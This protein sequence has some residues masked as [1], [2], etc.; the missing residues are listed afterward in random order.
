[1]S[2]DWLK[3]F[4]REE[5][6]ELFS[7]IL[8]PDTQD[9]EHYELSREFREKLKA[10]EKRVRQPDYRISIS[11]YTTLIRMMSS[12]I[13]V[14]GDNRL[15]M[16][17]VAMLLESF[18]H[19]K[20]LEAIADNYAACP[21]DQRATLLQLLACQEPAL[22]APVLK[23]LL[24]E[25]GFPDA[26][27]RVFWK[28]SARTDELHQYI[29][30]FVRKPGKYI[31]DAV[32]L[33]NGALEN[34]HL[35]PSQLSELKTLVEEKVI[36][37]IESAAAMQDSARGKWRRDQEY[38]YLRIDLG[39]W[40]D[41]FGII[42]ETSL[43]TLE[44]ALE[45]EDPLIN[46]FLVVA[47]AAKG[48]VPPAASVMSAAQSY[49]TLS[50]LYKVLSAKGFLQAF[51]MEYAT[52]EHFAAAEMVNWLL[53]PDELGEEPGEIELM[54][55]VDAE[56]EC[57]NS[58]RWC[59]W[60]FTDI[61]GESLAGVSGPYVQEALDNPTPKSVV[62]NDVFSNFTAWESAAPEEHLTGVLETLS[63]WRLNSVCGK[64]GS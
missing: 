52:F 16:I 56:D 53:Y 24:A 26:Y 33:S 2:T 8:D 14:C 32:D 25:H 17:N 27:P 7:A 28:L 5:W 57:G 51:P 9:S 18:A 62:S 23:Q 15:N 61:E 35:D 30:E 50:G 31:A 10:L 42:R 1:L 20:F 22:A 38:F 54:H 21:L 63:D 12:D 44:P 37:G 47:Y 39:A 58:Q 29:I 6:V 40:L 13:R 64:P 55:T 11:D 60:R 41:L 45:L 49:E 34:E 4:K 59:L 48:E 43:K 46:L 3:E 19:E 36:E